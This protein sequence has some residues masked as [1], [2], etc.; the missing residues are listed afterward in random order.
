MMATFMAAMESSIV[1]T[2]MPTI[3]A[4]LGG[5][6]LFSWAFAAY[7]LTQAVTIPIYGRL[8]DLY[9]RK[10]VF[11]AGAGLFLFASALCGLAWA[12]LPLILFRALQGA[13]AGAIQPIAT[14]IVGDIYKPTERARVQG[15]ISG[16]FGVAAIIGPMLGAFLVEHVT[17][18]LVFWI[19]LPIGAV[20]FVMFGLFL[21]ERQLPRRHRID[22]LGSTL[23]ML[24]VGGLMLALVEV[25]NSGGIGVIVALAA[26]GAAA[27][28]A[29]ATH[30]R[31][32][33]E[34]ILP[35]RL[36]RD[37]VIAVGSLSGF[38]GGMVMMAINAFLPLY[39]Q[40]A[41]GRSPAAAGLALGAASVSW[42]FASV[43][44]GRL[45]IRTSYRL[46]ATIGG[47]SLIA[48][49]LVLMSLGPASA[50]VWAGFGSLLIGIGMGFCNTSFLVSTQASVGWNERGMAT[51]SIM[52]MRIVGNSVGAAVFGAIL[53]FGINRRIPGAGD[54]VNRLLEPAARQ[55]LGAAEII[56]LSEAVA[57]SLNMVYIVAGLVA[58]VSLLLALALPARLSPTRPH[59]R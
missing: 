55:A 16:V 35:L 2:A 10:R 46:A 26:G 28:W 38:T 23:M 31:G 17:W 1:A 8:A 56:R 6:R 18:S 52:F 9:G 13:G 40:G 12:M 45:M 30:E 54:A 14:T 34:P 24:G 47:I 44:A 43:A 25:G 59:T 49:T 33:A 5:F 50:L 39:V 32:A 19:N 58:V 15:Y 22:Y 29:L 42:T 27:L 20:T 41:M 4:E 51:S 36:W 53:N 37:R 11:Y 57:G 48:G 7:L 21:H 3:V